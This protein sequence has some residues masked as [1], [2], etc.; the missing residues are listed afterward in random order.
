MSRL[1]VRAQIV[2]AGAADVLWRVPTADL[3]PG[4]YLLRLTATRGPDSVTRD[5]VFRRE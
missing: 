5:V 1:T 4:P 2:A 3:A